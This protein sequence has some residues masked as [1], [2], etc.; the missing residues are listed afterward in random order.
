MTAAKP[1][2]PDQV[3]SVMR[4]AHDSRRI[5]DTSS[6]LP[7]SC[8]NS[9]SARTCPRN[10]IAPVDAPPRNGISQTMAFP[11]GVLSSF[12]NSGL[13]TH[14]R[15]KLPFPFRR[16]QSGGEGT[17]IGGG[18]ETEFPESL[19]SQ[20]GVWEREKPAAVFLEPLQSAGEDSE[21]SGI[22]L[23]VSGKLFLS[24]GKP[25]SLPGRFLMTA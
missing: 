2:L 6:S 1:K 17:G 18:G 25:A 19:R 5:E 20:T 21:M 7:P 14:R 16:K 22:T 10:S 3:R 9:I 23:Q 24:F 12:P 4:T 15:R 13:G 11:N 8:R